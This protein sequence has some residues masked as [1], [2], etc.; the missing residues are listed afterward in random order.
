MAKKE[1]VKKIKTFKTSLK[2]FLIFL[3]IVLIAVAALMGYLIYNENVKYNTYKIKAAD[4]LE[5]EKTNINGVSYYI[6]NYKYVVNKKEYY[7]KSP[8]L[9]SGAPDKII[10]IKYNKNNPSDI[11]NENDANKYLIILIVSIALVVIFTVI[12]VS[13]T[14]PN[15]NEAIIVEVVEFVNCVGGRR[16]YLCD[17]SIP[18]TSPDYYDKKYYA[19]FTSDYEKFKVGNRLVFNKYKYGEAFTTEAYRTVRARSIYNFKDDDF[20]LAK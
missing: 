14:P 6:G 5:T 7:Y 3:I 12:A 15:L 8:T 18:N 19:Y 17:L 2:H 20:T 9:Y 1:K 10:Q 13:I 16:V 11:Y 4:L